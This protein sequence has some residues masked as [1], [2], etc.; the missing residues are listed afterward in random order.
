MCMYYI[1]IYIYIERERAMYTCIMINII[2][3]IIVIL[4]KGDLRQPSGQQSSVC[5]VCWLSRCLFGNS[6]LHC[7]NVCKLY[8]MVD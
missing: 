3:T 7:T 6:G 1:C 5:S 4:C 2:I 8:C